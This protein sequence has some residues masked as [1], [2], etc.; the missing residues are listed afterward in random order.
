MRNY[1]T[2]DVWKSAM[3]LVKN[4]YLLTKNYPKEELYALSSQTKRASVS[5]PSNI[6]EGMGRQYKKDTIHFLHI[7][8]GS[9]Y[10]L[11]TVLNI[12]VMVEI[13]DNKNF[14]T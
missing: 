9:I 13:I 6:A 11:E 12:D 1:Q 7:A 3:E 5:I 8:R 14:N 4:A 2:L 10:E